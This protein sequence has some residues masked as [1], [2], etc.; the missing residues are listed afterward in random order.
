M[1]P[2]CGRKGGMREGKKARWEGGKKGERKSQKCNME[3][4]SRWQN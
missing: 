1:A 2:F 3:F 4:S